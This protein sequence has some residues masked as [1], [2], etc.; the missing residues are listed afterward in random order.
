MKSQEGSATVAAMGTVAALLLIGMLSIGATGAL[1]A[2]TKAQNAA[3]LSALAAA[4]ASPSA[5]MVGDPSACEI[6]SLAA[7]HNDAEPPS[8]WVEFGDIWV[9]VRY[10]FS[11]LGMSFS[12]EARARAGPE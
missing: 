8:C 12:V 3:D 1:V 6:A 5:L 4:N 7:V 2:K 11:F 10:P 9:K